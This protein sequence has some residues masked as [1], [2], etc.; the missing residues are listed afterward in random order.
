MNQQHYC[1]KIG[2]LLGVLCL[3]MVSPL[4][5][6][7]RIF[8]VNSALDKVQQTKDQRSAIQIF[9]GF[10][11][12][13][14][15]NRIQVVEFPKDSSKT[16]A[17]DIVETVESLDVEEMPLDDVL[18]EISSQTGIIFIIPETLPQKVSIDVEH[19]DVW[20]LLKI[21]LQKNGLAYYQTE[22][23]VHIMSV[24]VFKGRYGYDFPLPYP[25]MFIHVK[26]TNVDGLRSV[27]DQEKGEAGRIWF[28][29]KYNNVMMID[30]ADRLEALEKII[31]EYDQPLVEKSVELRYTFYSEIKG[32]IEP[33]LTKGIGKIQ[34]DESGKKLTITDTLLKMEK[35]QQLLEKVDV[36]VMKRFWFKIVRVDLNEEHLNGVDWEAIVSDFQNYPLASATNTQGKEQLSFGTLTREDY[37]VLIDALDTVG[38]LNHLISF[39]QDIVLNQDVTVD[40]ETNDPFWSLRQGAKAHQEEPVMMDP[41]G[42]EMRANIRLRRKGAGLELSLLPRLHWMVKDD[43]NV[44]F[45]GEKSSVIEVNG[46]DV[47]VIG[48]LVH[49]K[50]VSKTQKFPL[51]GDLPMVGNVFRRRR[52]N[53]NNTEYIIFI[54]PDFEGKAKE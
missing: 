49:E 1:S 42:F 46:E 19:I 36:A 28:D 37:D 8:A 11:S 25:A 54:V 43:P 4:L 7:S 34:V 29:T 47:V 2:V 3:M 31:R 9:D 50:E 16:Q 44:L 12:G 32:E 26:D 45:V 23:A 20:D 13:F 6:Q 39:K 5:A 35:I 40:M 51:L 15:D 30:S 38:N 24:D 17:K 41:N 10:E 48:G 33:L 52:V 27:L 18:D 53:F 22:R 21:L 14:S